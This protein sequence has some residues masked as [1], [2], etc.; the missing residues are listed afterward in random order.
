MSKTPIKFSA[1][2]RMLQGNALAN[3][4]D[5]IRAK[6]KSQTET[7]VGGV[8]DGLQKVGKA[9]VDKKEN[10]KNEIAQAKKDG[11]ELANGVLDAGG[12]LGNNHYD[13]FNKVV[14]Q[15]GEQNNEYEIDGDKDGVA[16]NGT[17]MKEL[18]VLT[19]Q[20]KDFRLD[21]AKT[22]DTVSVDGKEMPNFTK[23]L[24]ADDQ[25]LFK[26][27][28]DPNTPIKIEDVDGKWVQ[29]MEYNGKW[30]TKQE[31][32]NK[33]ADAKEDVVSINQVQKLRDVVMGQAAADIAVSGDEKYGGFDYEA[34]KL[35]VNKILKTANIVSLIN[36]DVLG[37]GSSFKDDLFDAPELNKITYESIGM[38]TKPNPYDTDGDGRLSPQEAEKI[39]KED[40]EKIVDALTNRSNDFFKEEATMGLMEGYITKH[41][42]NQYNKKA[43]FTTAFKKSQY[44]VSDED[45]LANVGVKL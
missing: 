30:Y 27:V 11:Q 29:S 40:K 9:I 44:N 39:S 5:L 28:L 17:R 45:I 12:G 1:E 25:N 36:D 33:L 16:K 43:G 2:Q 32:E 3:E 35:Q 24:G 15:L 26:A 34:N 41:L 21:V 31:L 18:K 14:K 22:F 13:A 7:V 38:G 37:T 19:E 6:E 10:E 8:A 42:E 20:T 4:A 23:N